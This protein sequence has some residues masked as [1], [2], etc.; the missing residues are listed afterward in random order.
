MAF[1]SIHTVFFPRRLTLQYNTGDAE[2]VL[3]QVDCTHSE[4]FSLDAHATA[5]AVEDGSEISDHIIQKGRTLNIDGSV[6]DSPINLTTAMIGNAAGIV[7]G[8]FSGPA[9]TV[10]T[11]AAVILGNRMV[12]ASPKPARAALDVFEEI[13]EK[14]VLLTIVSGLATF[15]NMVMERFSPLRT[16]QNAGALVFSASFREVRIV[17]SETV[18]VPREALSEDTRDLGSSEKQAGRQQSSTLS[19]AEEKYASW[20]YQLIVGD[21]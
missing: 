21:E 5:H 6:S 9:K 1:E 7:G 15:T 13:Y 17:N 14:K 18:A 19:D 3:L 10:A 11:A 2:R 8:I 16:A 20:L 12:A 4:R